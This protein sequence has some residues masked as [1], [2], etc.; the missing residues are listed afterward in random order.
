MQTITQSSL[1]TQNIQVLVQVTSTDGYNPTGDDVS[2]AFTNASAFPAQSPGDDD[3]NPGTWVT[4]PGNLFYA[5]VLVGPE[6]D[7]VVL[8]QGSWQCWLRVQDS[9]EIPVMQPFVLQIV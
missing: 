2:F 9:P 7:G 6:N 3:W 5:Q 1:S 4:Y 8:S